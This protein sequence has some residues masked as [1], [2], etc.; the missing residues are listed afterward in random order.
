MQFRWSSEAILMEVMV[1]QGDKIDKLIALKEKQIV[2]H[3]ARSRV[4]DGPCRQQ[5]Q[6]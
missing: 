6:G 2:F 4:I 5:A 1:E 3:G